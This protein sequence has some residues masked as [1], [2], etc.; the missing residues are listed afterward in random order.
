MQRIVSVFS[1]VVLGSVLAWA[2]DRVSLLPANRPMEQAIDIWKQLPEEARTG[3]RRDQLMRL[4][5]MSEAQRLTNMRAAQRV[6]RGC[7]LAERTDGL[8]RAVEVRRGLRVDGDDVGA[9][10]RE[11]GEVG[12]GRSDHQVDVEDLGGG[13]SDRLRR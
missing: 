8:Q 10:F 6:C 9:G 12:I 3:A 13:A 7:L 4:Y 2:D 11:G 5:C 1:A